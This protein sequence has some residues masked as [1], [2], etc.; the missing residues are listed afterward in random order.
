MKLDSLLIMGREV[1]IKYKKMEDHGLFEQDEDTIY[2]SNKLKGNDLTDTIIHEA[3][4]AI[5]AYSGL[6][7]LL[8]SEL[9]EA[10][11]RCIE[12]NLIPIINKMQKSEN[13][14]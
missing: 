12:Y 9:E 7:E 3:T 13:N 4:H 8:N 6:N 1:N 14:S 2:I 11:V 10:L 5:L